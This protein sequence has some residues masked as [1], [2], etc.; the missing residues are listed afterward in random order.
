[1]SSPQQSTVRCP[2]CRQ[3]VQATIYNIVDVGKEPRLK[4]MLLRGQINALSC[5]NCGYRGALSMPMLYHD[6]VKQ[7]A[8][9][10]MPPELGLKRDEEERQIGK[11]TNALM[12]S[13]PQ[14]QRKMYMLQ[15]QM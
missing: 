15:P 3:P 2:N 6:P 10:L 8:L 1:M 5:P 13:I 7:L 9:V 12:E 14:E 4:E 11:L